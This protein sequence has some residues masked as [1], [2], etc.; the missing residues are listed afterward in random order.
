VEKKTISNVKERTVHEEASRLTDDDRL[1]RMTDRCRQEDFVLRERRKVDFAFRGEVATDKETCDAKSS[2][3]GESKK[4]GR[5]GRTFVTTS[6][7]RIERPNRFTVFC[8]LHPVPLDRSFYT[9]R[10][11]ELIEYETAKLGKTD[12]QL[13]S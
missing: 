2:Q 1:A 5:R 8:D 6:M 11:K 7:C 4:G 10:G 13:C 12:D 3:S 9:P